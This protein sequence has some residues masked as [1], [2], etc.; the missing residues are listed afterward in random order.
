MGTTQKAGRRCKS[1]FISVNQWF[2]I[3]RSMRSIAPILSPASTEQVRGSESA[4]Q[5][6]LVLVN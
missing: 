6:W 3:L 1:A 4:K 2:K 5:A